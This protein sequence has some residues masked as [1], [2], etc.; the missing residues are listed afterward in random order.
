M[1]KNKPGKGKND[2]PGK[3][4]KPQ[5]GQSRSDYREKLKAKAAA[6]KAQQEQANVQNA[7]AV[8]PV[9]AAPPKPVVPPTEL[10][11]LTKVPKVAYAPYNFVPFHQNEDSTMRVLV[12]YDS[13]DSLP[14][15]D[16]LD[17][18]LKTG[19]IHIRLLAETPVFVSDGKKQFFRSANGE[20]AIPGS[21]VRGLVRENMQILGFGAVQIEEDVEDDYILYRKIGGKSTALRKDLSSTYMRAFKRED[22]ADRGN[23]GWNGRYNNYNRYPA[24]DRSRSAAAT[25]VLA[26]YLRRDDAGNF[27][28]QP[29]KGGKPIRVPRTND[30][31]YDSGLMEGE[32]D[33]IPVV[34]QKD[35]ENNV[36]YVQNDAAGAKT[37][38]V[39][40]GFLLYT[41][42]GVRAAN[43]RYIFPEADENAAA[44]PVT[45]EEIH[46]YQKDYEARMNTLPKQERWFWEVKDDSDFE[47]KPVFY[48]KYNNHVWFGMSYYMRVGYQHSIGE[49]V[50]PLPPELKATVASGRPILDYPHAMLGYIDKSLNRGDESANRTVDK[51]SYRS[52]VSFG[53]FY[54]SSSKK[55]DMIRT[56][57]GGPKPSWFEGYLL[58]GKT[59]NANGFALRGWKQYFMKKPDPVPAPRDANDNVIST[60]NPLEEGTVFEGVISYKNLHEDELGLLLWS[61]KLGEN[62]RQLI[63][64]GKPYGL[65]RM[66]VSVDKLVEYDV[67][68]L[69]TADG[70][71]MKPSKQGD[72]QIEKY[73]HAFD[74]F[75]CEKLGIDVPADGGMGLLTNP[76]IQDFLFLHNTVHTGETVKYL[77]FQ[78]K[79]AGPKAG[80]NR[81]SQ[82]GGAKNEFVDLEAPLATVRDIRAQHAALKKGK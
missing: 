39:E 67:C 50:P 2:Q 28:I 77:K 13:V 21:T 14:S 32:A 19:E 48:I 38:G 33:F 51:S 61:L 1:G 29:V 55:A 53:D 7:P 43:A 12:R 17:P 30:A 52:R 10:E 37:N 46:M 36:T 18:S 42:K 73:I 6:N 16:T 3:G 82:G 56:I 4:K 8:E 41:G 63:G 34:Y 26:G 9:K 71:C 49:G 58:D 69:Y 66:Y 22:E 74:T 62:C 15:H 44:V 20:N 11:A 70:L 23:R 72:E 59:Y 54:V 76:E 47:Q 75:A 68:S 64:M 79:D 57:L 45:S 80:F 40:H 5:H 35:R 24:Q 31:L 65:G 60:L 78:D 27:T 25:N 81:G